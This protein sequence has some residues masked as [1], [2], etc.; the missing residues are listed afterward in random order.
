[1]RNAI[2]EY[3]NYTDEEKKELWDHAT[4][5]FD[6]NV[7]LNL[8]R[9][10]SRTRKLLISSFEKLQ[11]RLWMPNHVAH[12]FMKNRIGVIWE[13][14]NQYALLR[15]EAD[16]FFD[17]CHTSLKLDQ[18]DHE[19]DDL[20]SKLK[21]WIDSSMQKNVAVTNPDSDS[22]L[23][24]LLKLYEGKVGLAY[25]N[26]E[27]KQIEQEGRQRYEKSVPPGYKDQNKQK[28]NDLNNT[29]GD[30]IV[31][32]QILKYAASEKKDIILVTNDQKEDWWEILHGQTHGPRIELK[33]EF[34]NET[35]QKFHMY[36]MRSFITRFEGGNED[37]IDPKTIDEIIFFSKI[38]HHKSDKKD[39]R[40]YYNSFENDRDANAARLRFAIMRLEN[41]NHKR[42][43]VIQNTKEKYSY[44][45][46]PADIEAMVD[47][48]IAKLERD[49]KRIAKLQSTLEDE[50]NR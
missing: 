40:E 16:K 38:I 10:T 34:F 4:F 5:V 13:T 23:D 44:G 33:K 50:N 25:S 30:L 20:K 18:T 22:I 2:Q 14:N 43:R 21:A 39:L 29:Y 24:Q 36:T 48:T 7:Y 8:Y 12:E 41:K 47:N 49:K 46:M 17:Q 26:E 28:S 32:K 1:M 19:L 27:M 45:E 11:D 35:K 15:T 6:T 31:W 3:L 9:Y 37:K 42:L